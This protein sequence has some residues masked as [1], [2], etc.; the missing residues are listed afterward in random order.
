MPS[1]VA[2]SHHRK[3]ASAHGSQAW[4]EITRTTRDSRSRPAS[5]HR[6]EREA[7]PVGEPVGVAQQ[8]DVDAALRSRARRRRSC[9]IAIEKSEIASSAATSMRTIVRA[10][11]PRCTRAMSQR[12]QRQRDV[13]RRLDGQR[14]RRADAA[15]RRGQPRVLQEPVVDPPVAGEDAAEPDR[16]GQDG[17]RQPVGGDD[18]QHAPARVVADPRRRA[19]REARGQERAVEQEARDHEEEARRPCSAAPC[20]PRAG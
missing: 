4:S 8:Q 1:C 19:A 9:A 5:D 12:P 15:Q 7:H 16:R 17:Q 20:R 10:G 6:G 14:P 18:A 11:R 13:E 2:S 3:A